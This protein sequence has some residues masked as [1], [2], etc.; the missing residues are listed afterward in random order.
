MDAIQNVSFDIKQGQVVGFLGPNGA[1]K[2]TTMK[3]ISGLIPATSGQASVFGIS[4]AKD[5]Q[6]IQKKISFL[7]EN[8]PLPEEL[9]VIEYLR[10]R[11]KIKGIPAKLRKERI[12]KAMDL[13]DLSRKG[14][15]RIIGDL[16]KGFRQRVGI[17]DALLSKPEIIIMDEP[18]I[19]L[20]PHQIQMTRDLISSMRGEITFILSSH[21]LPEIENSCDNIIIINQGQVVASG[22]SSELR[23]EFVPVTGYRLEL[24]GDIAQFIELLKKSEKSINYIE[25]ED[26]NESGSQRL[27]IETK[28]DNTFG[29]WI[30]NQ[31]SGMNEFSIYEVSKI[32]P[33]LEDIF[34]IATKRSWDE[35]IGEGTK[36]FS[37]AGKSRIK[38]TVVR[39]ENS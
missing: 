19:G 20:D 17:A 7:P 38:G 23:K 13:C 2:T 14:K 31:T 12:Y 1:G 39:L 15:N 27:F 8:N 26:K 37:D 33:T 30:I 24:K 9:R 34:M 22:A 4:V 18:T 16:S 29:E 6:G 36:Y 21:I 35:K 3:I 28:E 10:F 5:P 32:E 25:Y 11:S